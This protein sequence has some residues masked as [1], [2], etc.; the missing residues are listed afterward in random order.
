M[1]SNALSIVAFFFGV[2]LRAKDKMVTYSKVR[3]IVGFWF[4]SFT[5][6]RWSYSQKVFESKQRFLRV[7]K[8]FFESMTISTVVL[9]SEYTRSLTCQRAGHGITNRVPPEV[10]RHG[11][12]PGGRRRSEPA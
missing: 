10:L 5:R 7:K 4:C 3:T 12:P 2:L 1:V 11:Q 6:T 8:V 9:P